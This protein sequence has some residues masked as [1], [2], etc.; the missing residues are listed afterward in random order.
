MGDSPRSRDCPWGYG[1][2]M[3][4]AS[5]SNLTVEE[6]RFAAFDAC[7][8]KLSH[9][10]RTVLAAAYVDQAGIARVAAWGFVAGGSLRRAP[11]NAS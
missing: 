5:R 8:R 1:R 10:D 7:L 4:T 9:K 6:E 11:G 2:S 3:A